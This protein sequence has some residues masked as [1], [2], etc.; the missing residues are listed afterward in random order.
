M[1]GVGK[2]MIPFATLKLLHEETEITYS[3]VPGPFIRVLEKA[4]YSQ[5]IGENQP[6]LLIIDI[7][8]FAWCLIENNFKKLFI[9]TLP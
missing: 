9:D 4:L 6:Y 1:S 7:L 3:Y 5:Q 2:N 8:H